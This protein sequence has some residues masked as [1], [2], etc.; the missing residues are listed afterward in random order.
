MVHIMKEYAF[1]ERHMGT[2]VT[3]SL[4]VTDKIQAEIIANAIFKEISVFEKRFSRFLPDSELSQLNKIGKEIVSES[5][6]TVLNKSLELVR[7]TNG[8][9]NPLVQVGSLGYNKNFSDL[10][11][12]ISITKNPYNTDIERIKINQNTHEV[13]LAS[14]QQL[15]F[16]GV[17]KG[18]LAD[19]LTQQIKKD[20]KACAGCIINI[21]GDIATFGYDEFHEP[22][23]FFIYNP[24][25]H[26]EIPVTLTDACLATSGTYKRLWQ[27]NAGQKHHLV[28]NLTQENSNTD[29]ISVSIIHNEGAIA[30]AYTKLFF[31]RS[32]EEALEISQSDNIGY[33]LINNAGEITSNIL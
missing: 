7:K 5:F 23:I 2:E 8:A 33:V 25:T 30:E 28:N 15:D 10:A 16:G 9:F 17:L 27:T 1:S 3:V 13:I 12:E 32:Q 21:G 6:L 22:F 20:Y 31:N 26:E 24:I 11:P 29:L 4:I 14:H 19:K 18:Y